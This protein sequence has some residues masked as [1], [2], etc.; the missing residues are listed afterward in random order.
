MTRIFLSIVSICHLAIAGCSQA[1]ANISQNAVPPVTT[2]TTSPRPRETPIAGLPTAMPTNSKYTDLD[3]NACKEI[4][5]RDT[6]D[7]V[8]YKAECPGF[9]GYKVVNLSTDHTQGLEITDPSGRSFSID[10]RAPLG[11]IGDL[12]L[13]D[14]IEWRYKGREK[15][16]TPYAFIVRVNVQKE[17]GK[18]EKQDSFLGV[19]K[20]EKDAVCV[21]DFVKPSVNDQNLKAREI[22]D[23]AQNRP[24]IKSKFN[25]P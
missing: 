22:S 11:V 10:F 25:Q 5:R 9:A 23:T 12:F 20:I 16:L 2:Q 21:T 7:G 6:D 3:D 19:V 17:P 15:D 14:K 24:C 18:P 8:L 4:K 13:G 1:E